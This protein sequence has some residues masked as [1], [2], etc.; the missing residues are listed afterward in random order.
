MES[1]WII[2][3]LTYSVIAIIGFTLLLKLIKK[4]DNKI[5]NVRHLAES[6][7]TEDELR[8]AWERLTEVNKECW[9]R[10]DVAKIQEIKTIILLKAKDTN[11]IVINKQ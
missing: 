3:I 7:K 6:A 2:F 10:T 9:H 11:T 8:F 5:S 1:H 4:L